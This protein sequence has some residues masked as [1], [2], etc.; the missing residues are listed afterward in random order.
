M[1]W[2][3]MHRSRL[4][5]ELLLCFP[6]FYR[7]IGDPSPSFWHRLNCYGQKRKVSRL[8]CAAGQVFCVEPFPLNF[9]VARRDHRVHGG[10]A[11][12]PTGSLNTLYRWLAAHVS[13]P[14]QPGLSSCPKHRTTY[15]DTHGFE[16]DGQGPSR[17]L[18]SGLP[19]SQPPPIRGTPYMVSTFMFSAEPAPDML[20]RAHRSI[21]PRDDVVW[22]LQ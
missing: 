10:G 12:W 17:I 21:G 13:K 11:L 7:T 15:D 14:A 9:E 22:L 16:Q 6:L 2:R 8:P 20:D 5:L 1:N 19:P 3:G 4:L 18:D